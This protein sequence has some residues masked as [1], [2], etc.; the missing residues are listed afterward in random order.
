MRA[1]LREPFLLPENIY[2]VS[3]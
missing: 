1:A 3:K 2:R